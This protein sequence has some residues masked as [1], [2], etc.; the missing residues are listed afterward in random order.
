MSEL[1]GEVIESARGRVGMPFRHHFKPDNLCDG[2]RITVDGCTERGMDESGYDC[3]GLVIASISDVLA[4]DPREW[5]R[6]L[7]HTKQLDALATDQD[8]EPG[9]ILMH[10]SS[11]GRIHMSIATGGREG[12]HAS[13]VTKLVEEGEVTDKYGPF[14]VVQAIAVDALYRIVRERGIL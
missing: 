6:D 12:I 11:N 10:H 7:R 8:F 9:D 13:G 3:S 1:G 4:V 2:G 14:E 5:P